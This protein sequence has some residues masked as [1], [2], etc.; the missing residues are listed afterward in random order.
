MPDQTPADADLAR[1]FTRDDGSFLCA[2]WARPIVPVVFGA[3][4]ETLATVKGAIETVVLLAG[5]RMAE[6]DPEQGANLFVFFLRDW[7]E[8]AAVPDLDRLLGGAG[9]TADLVARLQAAGAHQ[10]RSFRF[11]ASGAIRAGFVFLRI[12]GPL[13]EIPA[14]A[15]ALDEAVRM[16]LTWGPA[17]F[18]DRAALA[19]ANGLAVIRPGIAALVAAAY[20][21][22]LPAAATDPVH[23]LRLRARLSKDLP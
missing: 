4:D 10:Y 18:R 22:V 8:L 1:F 14:D 15:L 17:A 6:T 12:A 2:R 3:A 19:E 23:A 9:A 5:H 11:E 21:P 20:D 13:A 7:A 16:I